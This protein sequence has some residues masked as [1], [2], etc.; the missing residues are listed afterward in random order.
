MT[1][2]EIKVALNS[3]NIILSFKEN[4]NCKVFVKGCQKHTQRS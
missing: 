3:G 1:I 2:S 4:Y